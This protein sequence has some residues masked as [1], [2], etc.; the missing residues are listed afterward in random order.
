[1]PFN[2]RII[3]T[4]QSILY[5]LRIYLEIKDRYSNTPIFH[6]RFDRGELRLDR[7]NAIIFFFEGQVRGYQRLDTTYSTYF[8]SFFAVV[9]LTVFAFTSIALSAFQVAMSYS[10]VSLGLAGAGYWFSIVMMVFLVALIA[11][12]ILWFVIVFMDNLVYSS[13]QP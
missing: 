12:Y 2:V 10:N 3:P 5:S 4:T 11:A 13:L 9:S 6:N 1:M 8:Q 7:L